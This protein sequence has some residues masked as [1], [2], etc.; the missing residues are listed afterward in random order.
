MVLVLR[1][2]ARV[3]VVRQRDVPPRVLK[4]WPSEG[5]SGTDGEGISLQF[6]GRRRGGKE[7]K[8]RLSSLINP[9]VMKLQICH[10]T[11]G[12]EMAVPT[13]ATTLMGSGIP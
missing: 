3:T 6:Q 4:A 11:T 13:V 7:P 8:G 2:A 10:T 5:C 9:G 1:T 12:R